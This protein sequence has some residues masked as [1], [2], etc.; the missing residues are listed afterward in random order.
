MSTVLEI[1]HAIE[2]LVPNDRA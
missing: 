1:E 2:Q